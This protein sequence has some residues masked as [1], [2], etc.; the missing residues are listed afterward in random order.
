MKQPRDEKGRFL[1]WDG[2]RNIKYNERQLRDAFI[3]GLAKKSSFFTNEQ[4]WQQYRKT[5]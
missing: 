3:A 5:L 2:T 1:S 4:L